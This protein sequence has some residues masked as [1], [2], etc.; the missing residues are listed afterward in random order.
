MSDKKELFACPCC[1]YK[2]LNELYDVE[3]GTGYDICNVCWWEDDGK[4][5]DDAEIGTSPNYGVSLK[6]ARYNFIKFG[7][8]DPER[9]NLLKKVLPKSDYEVGRIF[10]IVGENVVEIVWKGKI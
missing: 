3:Q 8:Y 2:T 5:N 9:K 10:E 6:Q 4:D 1:G 7:I